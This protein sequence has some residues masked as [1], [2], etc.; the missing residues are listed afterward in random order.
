[1]RVYRIAKAIHSSTGAQMMSGTGGL[2]GSARWHTKGRAIIY[3]ATSLALA[4]LE[5]A[6][7]LKMASVILAYHILEIEVPDKLVVKIELPML[8]PGWD[9]KDGEPLLARSIGD[10]WLASQ[11]SVGLLVP[12][13][14]IP[15]EYNVLLNPTHPQFNQVTYGDP[16]DFPFDARIK[17]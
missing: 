9:R 8:P 10:R 4:T 3:T 11:V 15:Q 13:A 5:I 2:Y 1:M 7:N 6:V 17:A 12:S 16:L 14:V